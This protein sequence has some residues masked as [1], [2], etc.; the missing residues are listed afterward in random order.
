MK[1]EHFLIDGN[2]SIKD[3]LKKIDQ[4]SFGIIFSKKK[5]GEVY[6]AATDG[7]IRRSLIAGLDLDD[8]LDKCI[9]K[10]FYWEHENASREALIKK[11]D[12]KHLDLDCEEF[13]QIPSTVENIAIVIWELLCP[14]LNGM[15]YK[16][17]VAE[18]E[19]NTA[20]YYGP[21]ST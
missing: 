5:S 15:L 13:K 14:H 9:N 8:K 19:N 12:H 20:T 18:T 1:I 7:D 3:A 4:N 6:G 2:S 21:E 17:K 11:F 10:E 16:I